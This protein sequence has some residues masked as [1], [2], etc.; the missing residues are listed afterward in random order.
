VLPHDADT[1][2]VLDQCEKVYV[3]T[4]QVGFEALLRDKEV[5]VFGRPFYSG[6]GLTIDY[7]PIKRRDQS[8]TI[9]KLFYAACVKYSIYYDFYNNT[10]IS[11]EEALNLVDKVRSN[12]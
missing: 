4:S 9:E 1:C 10:L 5:H 3:A 2:L 8:L 6:W 7:S 12:G 11:M